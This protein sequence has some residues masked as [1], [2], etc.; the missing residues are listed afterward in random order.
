MTPLYKPLFA[1]IALTILLAPVPAY[2]LGEPDEATDTKQE[3]VQRAKKNAALKRWLEQDKRIF[4]APVQDSNQIELLLIKST[5]PLWFVFSLGR[6]T[7]HDQ[8]EDGAKPESKPIKVFGKKEKDKEAIAQTQKYTDNL[9]TGSSTGGT[10]LIDEFGQALVMP[11]NGHPTRDSGALANLLTEGHNSQARVLLENDSKYQKSASM[12]NNLAMLKALDGD[13]KGGVNILCDLLLDNDNTTKLTGAAPSDDATS[14]AVCGAA[15][16]NLAYLRLSQGRTRD[17]NKLLEELVKG[18]GRL[19]LY[20]LITL[21][22]ISLIGN[23]NEKAS[24]YADLALASYRDNLDVLDIAGDIAIRNK[25]YKKAIDLLTPVAQSRKNDTSYLLK[26]AS[27]YQSMGNLDAA[28]K[29][30][31]DA[32]KLNPDSAIVHIELGKLH[33][34]NKEFLGAKLQFERAMELN[35]PLN[36]ARTCFAAFIKVLNIMN[37]DK[38]LNTWTAKWVK[39][40]PQ[41]AICQYNRGWYLTSAGKNKQAIEA[42]QAALALEPQMNT[43]R[44]NLIYLLYKESRPQEAKQQANVFLEASNSPE[45]KSKVQAMLKA[46][47]D[48]SK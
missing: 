28:I 42:Y 27:C 4:V 10:A 12:K 2:A 31:S 45:D 36:E 9:L 44:Y 23:D 32:T 48:K 16:F 14:G 43:A 39:D 19:K 33:L 5:P 37:D 47:E 15:R 29:L 41:A 8:G 30:L 22:R 34:L 35:P 46:I 24:H 7:I 13:V 25:Q 3:L 17:A 20:S 6:Y 21:G 26:M 11:S 38:G 18:G 40:Y 1:L